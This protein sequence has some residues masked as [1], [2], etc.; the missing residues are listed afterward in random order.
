LPFGYFRGAGGALI[1]PTVF[2][3]ATTPRIVNLAKD[4]PKK[5]AEEVQRELVVLALTLVGAM[6]IRAIIRGITRIGGESE[7]PVPEGTL[8]LRQQANELAAGLRSAGKPVKV[9]LAGA[10][11]VADAVNVNNLSAQQ[12]KGIPNLI[13]ANAEQV[14]EIFSE[15][16]VDA[17]VSNNVVR[18]QVNWNRT[19][20]GAYRILKPGGKISIAPYAGGLEAHMTEIEKALQDAGFEA[21]NREHG[22]VVVGIKR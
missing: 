13:K 6:A 4:L 2:S 16:S 7:V 10:G 5:L 8:R 11:E 15:G 3:A 1:A 12:A 21:V 22:A 18:G 19:A 9:N 14:G 20:K 17:V